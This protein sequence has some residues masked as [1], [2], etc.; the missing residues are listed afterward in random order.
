MNRKSH[1]IITCGSRLPYP[2]GRCFA[3]DE[4]KNDGVPRRCHTARRA[5]VDAAGEHRRDS[6]RPGQDRR[7]RSDLQLGHACRSRVRRRSVAERKAGREPRVWPR[8]HRAQRSNHST[9]S[10]RCRIRR[11]AVCR[12]RGSP[13]G[14]REAPFAV[15]GRPHVPPGTPRLRPQGHTG[16]SAH[17]Y[18]RHSRLAQDAV[19]GPTRERVVAHRTPA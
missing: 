4:D 7:H 6:V 8:G 14:R 13:F 9:D 3:P 18:Q 17:P 12:S 11:E 16:P 15:R 1:M 10:L 2:S 19:P 5:L